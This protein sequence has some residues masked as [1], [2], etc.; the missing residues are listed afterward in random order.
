MGFCEVNYLYIAT[1]IKE[2]LK[3]QLRSGPLAFLRKE[4]EV[5]YCSCLYSNYRIL[6]I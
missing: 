5:I 1:V 2:A 3:L 4:G 6:F